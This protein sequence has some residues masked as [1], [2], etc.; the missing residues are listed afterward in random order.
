M[1]V[2]IIIASPHGF[3]F[4]VER[5]INLA[6]ESVKKYD[7]PIYL[8]GEMVHNQHVIDELET[9]LRIK[10]VD[11]LDQIPQ[12][13]VVIIRAHGA[14]PKTFEQIKKR[15][16]TI[17]DATCPLVIKSHQ[18]ALNLIKNQR[19][20][21]FLCSSIT[22]DETVGIVGESPESI[23]PIALK[24][25]FEFEITDP[26]NTSIL[27]QTTLSTLETAKALEYLKTKYPNL[28]ILPHICPATTERQQAIIDLAKI[29]KFVIIVG[30][31]TSAN[32]NN[33]R[34]VAELSGATAHIV[35]NADELKSEW[36]I[37]QENIVVSSGAS[38]PEQVL[39]Q[40]VERIKLITHR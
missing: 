7:Q 31:P 36:F 29:Y 22:H 10:T 23:T 6:K 32:S 5:A 35:D 21:I 2:K 40:A 28:D 19:Q 39:N 13:S 26:Q 12:N 1:P 3:C 25:I 30:S 16:L 9:D 37:N 18:Q 38:T 34:Q 17:V 24:D 20:I 11:T 4:G 15:H 8:L 27:T 14:T 33:L